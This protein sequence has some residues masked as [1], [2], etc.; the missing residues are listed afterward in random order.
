MASLSLTLKSCA[1]SNLSQIR[2]KYFANATFL[3]ERLKKFGKNIYNLFYL[4]IKGGV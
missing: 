2:E 4:Y 3:H 1:E